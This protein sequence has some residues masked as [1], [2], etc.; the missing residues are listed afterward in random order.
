M[1]SFFQTGFG[2]TNGVIMD[3]FDKFGDSLEPIVRPTTWWGKLREFVI[4]LLQ[5]E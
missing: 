2:W 5:T 4:D 3:F 1:E